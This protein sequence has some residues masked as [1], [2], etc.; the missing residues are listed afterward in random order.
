[1]VKGIEIGTSDGL[2]LEARWDEEPQPHTA[3]IFCHPHPQHGGTMTAPLMHK[4]AKSLVAAGFAVLRFN[5]RGVGGS[6]GQWAG[7]EGEINDVAAAVALAAARELPLALTGWSF[8]AATALRWQA[9]ENDT[10]PYVGIAPPVLTEYMQTPPES[11]LAPAK[12]LF[13]LGDHDQ[14]VT[15]GDLE[16]YARSIG[17]TV[18]V[19]NGSDHFFYFRE[20]QVAALITEFLLG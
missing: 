3:L 12:R 11:D 6:S 16:S 14:F 5:F 9:R 8:G 13:I 17:A 18:E 19:I 10:T 2:R 15:V 4:V 20:A 7:G 1:M